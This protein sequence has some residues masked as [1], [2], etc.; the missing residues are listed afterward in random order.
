[1][2]PRRSHVTRFIG[3]VVQ[4]AC[5]EIAEELRKQ[6]YE[7]QVLNGE[8]G[9][10]KLN[11]GHGADV[12]FSYE[13]RPRA[14]LLPRFATRDNGDDNGDARKYFRAEVYLREGGQDYDVMGWSREE[15]IGDL[16]DQYEKHLHFLHVVR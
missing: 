16:L 8:E 9:R 5:E 4:P 12:D 11:V 2:F 6:G 13:V 1:M 3:E 10:C 7:V 14:F 15:V